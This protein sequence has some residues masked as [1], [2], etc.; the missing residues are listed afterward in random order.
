MDGGVGKRRQGYAFSLVSRK[1]CFHRFQV[2]GR[3]FRMH[4]LLRPSVPVIT[5]SPSELQP[6]ISGTIISPRVAIVLLKV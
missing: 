4:I 5:S 1:V 6:T 3:S 2:R